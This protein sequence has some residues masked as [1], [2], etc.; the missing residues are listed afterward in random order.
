[1]EGNVFNDWL[2]VYFDEVTPME[3]YRELFPQGELDGLGEFS[4]GKYVGII[5]EKTNEKK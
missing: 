2:S 5:V 1:M 3:F 4:K